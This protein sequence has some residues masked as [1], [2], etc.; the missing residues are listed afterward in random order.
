MSDL[1]EIAS[2]CIGVCTMS[3]ATGFCQGCYRTIEEI[4][5]WWDM[6]P[7]RK[8]EVLSATEQR[9]AEF[10]DFGD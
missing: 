9:M 5:E 1:N 2:P 6:A 8:S 10:A 4:R 7:E 3:E